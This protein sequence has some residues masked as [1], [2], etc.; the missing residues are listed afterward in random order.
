MGSIR[1]LLSLFFLF[2]LFPIY[3]QNGTSKSD[4][5]AVSLASEISRLEKIVSASGS[6]QTIASS[7]EQYD[8]Y[9][10]L[11]RLYQ[12]SGNPE[13]ALKAC[14]GALA[15]SPGDGRAL[16]LRARFL[17]F[18]GEFEKADMA[19]KTLPATGQN[20][21]LMIQAQYLAALLEAFRSG[22]TQPLAVLAG[23]PDFAGNLGAIYYT[24]WKLTGLSSWKSRL[25]TEIPQSPEAKIAA[26][27][28][29]VNPMPTPLWLFFPGRDSVVL[30]GEVQPSTPA[31]QP[32]KAADQSNVLQTGLFG[33]EANA[34]AMA[35]R[36]KKAGFE[37]VVVRKPLN[38]ADF[39]TV[40]VPYTND[41]NVVIQKLKNAGFESF[42]V[43]L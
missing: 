2:L 12:L 29:A 3:A 20:K 1:G 10:N 43:K 24:L 25:T 30:T 19:L 31:A 6:G 35:D 32:S 26:A 15:V 37:P 4:P 33:R 18:M 17:L 9:M 22:A 39:W 8:A 28:A 41:M 34:R 16:L 27:S 40:C 42:P 21:D 7:M 38:G 5:A 36:L 14:D 13:A 23:N 11:I